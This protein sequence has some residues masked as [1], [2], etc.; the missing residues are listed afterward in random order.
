[1]KNRFRIAGGSIIGS[2]HSK[3]GKPGAINNQ[4]SFFWKQNDDFLVAIV[5]DGCSSGKH[6]EVG[7]KIGAGILCQ[8]LYKEIENDEDFT[9][10]DFWH[11]ARKHLMNHFSGLAQG[12]GI[13]I[14]EIVKNYLLFTI[15][16]VIMTDE[17]TIIFSFGDGVFSI[18]GE[19]TEIGPFQRNAPP[20]IAYHLTGSSVFDSNPDLADFMIHKRVPTNEIT[21]L[22][23]GTDGVVD[24]VAIEDESI[25]GKFEKIG[26]INQ[27]FDEKFFKNPDM[28]RRRLAVIN[29]EV[30]VD[31]R[32]RAG[33]LKDDTTLVVIQ[34]S[35][36]QIGGVT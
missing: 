9:S 29:K 15:V 25:P 2:D 32:L 30:V 28:I 19:L 12:M 23:I 20:Y 27:F 21:N 16:G 8:L 6:S 10:A 31:G 22:V 17:L 18:D 3:P 33:H 24:L 34:N 7:A 14:S 11:K 5:A 26:S 1:M 13:S 35:F 4:D 36:C